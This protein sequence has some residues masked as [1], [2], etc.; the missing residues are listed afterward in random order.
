MS[1]TFTS[2]VLVWS[3]L[4][5]R[6]V[7]S[8]KCVV[9]SLKPCIQPHCI[10]SLISL[11]RRLLRFNACFNYFFFSQEMHVLLPLLLS[12]ACQL[13]T[14]YVLV[15]TYD[16]STWQSS[17]RLESVSHRDNSRKIQGTD[18]I[19]RVYQIINI[20]TTYLFPPPPTQA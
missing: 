18:F 5:Y 19:H 16:I 15:D 11:S 20:S 8:S 12:C 17:M 7:T 9:D 1:L 6:V 4:F 13:A 10:A 14:S 3:F 2:T